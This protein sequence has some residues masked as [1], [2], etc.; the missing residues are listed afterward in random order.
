MTEE[1][2]GPLVSPAS[3]EAERW[4]PR[5]LVLS[6]LLGMDRPVMRA[7]DLVGWCGRFG[8]Q[9]GTA[10]VAL[11]RMVDRGELRVTERGYELAGRVRARREDQ[12]FALSPR[13][14]QWDGAWTIVV[15]PE[16]ARPPDDR[17]ALRDAMRALRHAPM[18]DGVWT[19]PDNLDDRDV[20]WS[21]Y[22]VVDAQGIRFSARTDHDSRALVAELFAPDDWDDTARGLVGRL[23]PF[24]SAPIRDDE[25][26]P[27][28]VTGAAALR[29]LRRDPMLPEALVA[30]DRPGDA[31]RVA[32]GAFQDAF[33]EAVADWFRRTRTV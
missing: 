21:A 31:L 17:A 30:P 9:E 33:A 28:F 8:I 22:A 19:R 15:V 4:T 7:A 23:A 26:A 24:T 14:R 10:R 20:N 3:A 2:K 1:R 25:L 6:L 18:R 13:T 29:H 27:A 16:G 12:E 11:S 5:S 32:Y